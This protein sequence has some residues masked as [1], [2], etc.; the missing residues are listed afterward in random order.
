M[1]PRTYCILDPESLC[2]QCGLCKGLKKDVTYYTPHEEKEPNYQLDDE[3]LEGE[4]D[5]S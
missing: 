4:E 1:E 2:S 5:V 3:D